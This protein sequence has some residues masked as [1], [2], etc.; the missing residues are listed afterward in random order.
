L[1][2]YKNLPP[3]QL[4]QFTRLA[5]EMFDG[6]ISAQ[7]FIDNFDNKVVSGVAGAIAA[8]VLTRREAMLKYSAS[9]SDVDQT[10]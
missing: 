9:I 3:H 1:F 5:K 4:D 6:Q 10:L 7:Y 2:I 8:M